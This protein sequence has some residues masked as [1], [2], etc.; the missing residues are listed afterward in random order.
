MMILGMPWLVC[1]N[2]EIDWKIRKVKMT[3]YLEEY[4][5]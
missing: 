1:H 3:R 4:G 2:F 5:K